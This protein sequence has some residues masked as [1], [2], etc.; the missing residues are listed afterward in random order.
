MRLIGV[1]Q[2]GFNDLKGQ[3]LQLVERV[4]RQHG[5]NSHRLGFCDWLN[6]NEAIIRRDSGR[7]S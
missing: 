3:I 6:V 1:F 4:A 7:P 5:P 2:C